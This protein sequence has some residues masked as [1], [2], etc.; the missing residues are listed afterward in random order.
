MD[1]GTDGGA[2][3]SRREDVR[4][5]CWSWGADGAWAWA[6]AWVWV[7]AG[8]G[9]GWGWGGVCGLACVDTAA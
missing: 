2:S 4:V 7:W 5:V 8:A 9:A 1:G 3:A 6:W